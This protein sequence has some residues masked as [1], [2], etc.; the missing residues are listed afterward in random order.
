MK[1]IAVTGA[2]GF[3]G[4][5]LV[6][7]LRAR[8]YGVIALGRSASELRFPEDVELRTFDPNAGDPDAR[9]FDQAYA[10]VHLAGETVAGRWTAEKKRAIY[11]S[12]IRGTRK[13][14]A[15]CALAEEP[16]SVFI[17]SSATGYY[18]SRG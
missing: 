17:C 7:M 11:D 8:G 5:A 12:R 4:R 10:V 2:G 9:A 1:R 16:P 6:A 13:A 3:I 14:V 18:G 15:S